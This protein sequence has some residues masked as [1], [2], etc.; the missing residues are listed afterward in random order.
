MATDGCWVQF[1]DGEKMS[2]GTKRFD[3]PLEVS[4]LNDY[5][6]STGEKGGATKPI[7]LY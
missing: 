7:P 5:I 4:D 6:F 3:G 1:Y 2:G